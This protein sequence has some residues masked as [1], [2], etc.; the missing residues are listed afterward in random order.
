MTIELSPTY[1]ANLA[2]DIYG[3]KLT[4]TRGVFIDKYSSDMEL[5][6][7]SFPSGVTGGYIVKK[8]HLMAVFSAGKGTYKGQAF[9]AFKGTA[10]LYDAVTD[11]NAGIKT[12]HTGL[13][14]HQGFYYAFDSVL[15]E[16]RQFIG[17]LK[18]VSCVHCVGHSLGGAIATLAADWIKS[19]GHSATVNLY[20]F[21]SPRVGLARFANRCTSR[22]RADNVYRIYHKTDPIPMVPTWPFT[23]VPSSDADYL[24]HSPS[25]MPPW[26]YHFM[27]H[28]I[29][30]VE[31]TSGWKSIKRNRP[32]TYGQMTLEN[33]LKSDGVVSLTANS[34][35]LLDAALVYVL[36]KVAHAFGI[37]VTGIAAAGLT[38]LDRLAMIL[39]EAA[40]VSADLSIWVYHLVKK[41]AALVGISVKKGSSLTVEFIRSIFIHLHQRISDMVMRVAR[42]ID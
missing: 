11:L 28:Y 33:W 38:L 26:K 14:V 37:A 5:S 6:K 19:S 2:A 31:N 27:E 41:M 10:S 30:S 40:S 34:L 36:E 23:H 16:F 3:V 22:I 12:S 32:K 29:N 4:A 20:T 1:A 39:S 15:K 8:R 35:Q 13:P 9:I 25:A 24:I 18:G 17:D 42:Y 7:S 21:G